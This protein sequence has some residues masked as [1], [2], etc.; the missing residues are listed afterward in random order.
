MI[1][2]VT[3]FET[4]WSKFMTNLSLNGKPITDYMCNPVNKIS[5]IEFIATFSSWRN[6]ED[7][8]SDMTLFSLKNEEFTQENLRKHIEKHVIEIVEEKFHNGDVYFRLCYEDK[9]GYMCG[10]SAID[11]KE[12]CNIFGT[13]YF[14]TLIQKMN[15]IYHPNMNSNE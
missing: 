4:K 7:V 10:T 15:D 1:S 13:D 8:D 5:G 12:I 6:G 2:N 14:N 11:T 3:E 9:H